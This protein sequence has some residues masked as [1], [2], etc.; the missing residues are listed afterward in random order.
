[1][2]NT[3]S[4]Y[5]KRHT[6]I[7][8]PAFIEI[9]AKPVMAKVAAGQ[10]KKNLGLVLTTICGGIYFLPFQTEYTGET[11]PLQTLSSHLSHYKSQ[12][13]HL[14]PDNSPLESLIL[15]VFPMFNAQHSVPQ[16]VIDRFISLCVKYNINYKIFTTEG[17]EIAVTKDLLKT[18]AYFA[19]DKGLS[20]QDCIWGTTKPISHI[21]RQLL[22]ESDIPQRIKNKIEGRKRGRPRKIIEVSNSP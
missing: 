3:Q 18:I 19:S 16:S 11:N 6:A 17:G 20:T 12:P 5:I 9:I 1:M 14:K 2:I 22:E 13:S 7:P 8:L 15:P 4:K 10:I 21:T